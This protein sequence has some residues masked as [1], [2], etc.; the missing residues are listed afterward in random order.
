MKLLATFILLDTDLIAKKVTITKKNM[1][2]LHPVFD[3]VCQLNFV[4]FCDI[5]WYII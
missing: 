5:L 2:L 1:Q 4:I 3:N